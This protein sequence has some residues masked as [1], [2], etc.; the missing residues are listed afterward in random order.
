HGEVIQ[1]GCEISE[2]TVSR[3]LHNLNG[4]RDE[5]RAKRW[6]A[7]L[8]N[9]REVIATFDFFTVPSLTFRTLY[10][11]FV[12]EH[13]RRRILHFNVTEHPASDWIVQQLREALPLPCPYR[14]VL[15]DRDTKF[16]GDV[17]AFL[18]ASAMKPIRTSVR[19]PWQN[20]VAERWVGSVRRE[21]LDHVIPL[22]DQHLRRLGREYIAYYQEDR[23]HI[24]LEKTTPAGR[25]V[26][27]RP[28]EPRQPRALPRI[29][30]LHHRY[31][32]PTAA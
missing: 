26:E 6:L 17:V 30:G 25:P 11:F 7:F 23:T 24:G 31:T 5:G 3:Y 19:S 15:F 8:N 20:G 12:I 21:V 4:C 22:N 14:Y 1:L 10:C 28:T 13:G 27:P 29:G 32:W 16:G 18:H 9:H 2:P